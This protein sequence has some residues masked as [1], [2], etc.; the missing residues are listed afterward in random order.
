LT[1]QKQIKKF[2]MKKLENKLAVVTG[3]NS[4]I[5]L[6]TAKLF[7][8]EGAKVAIT[9]RNQSTIN[10]AVTEIGHG[11]LGLVSDV[12]DLNSISETFVKIT[13]S[14]DKKIDV[15]IVNAGNFLGAPLAEYTEALF[16]QTINVNFKGVFFTVQRA[17]PYLNDGASIVLTST[18]LNEKGLGIAAAYSAAKAAVRSLARSFSAELLS[19]NIRVNVLSPGAIDTPIFARTGGSKEEVDGMKAYFASAAPA[20]R[21]GTSEEIAAGFLYLASDDSRYMIGS[22]L[23]L[24][25]GVKGL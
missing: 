10:N 16:D 13:T 1:Y 12:N 15:L 8:T 11:A 6:A 9:G 14:F 19:R 21:L 3:G 7:A 25:G 18:A 4:G 5:G 24:D 17:L 2:R 22:E 20:K 23:I